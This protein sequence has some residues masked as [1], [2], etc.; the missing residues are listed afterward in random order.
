MTS[1]EFRAWAATRKDP[2]SDISGKTTQRKPG[3]SNCKDQMRG[4]IFNI[5]KLTPIE[6][7]Q[8]T[9]SRKFRFDYAFPDHKIAIEYEGL[10]CVT[11]AHTNPGGYINDCQK[12]N[13]AT[14]L[15]WRILRYTAN[16]YREILEDLP[17][18]INAKL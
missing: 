15:G 8:F 14:K 13:L 6:E 3:E 18:V 9:P 4:L 7:Y 12:Y 10:F 5:L 11:S 16:N 2:A 1:E 17:A